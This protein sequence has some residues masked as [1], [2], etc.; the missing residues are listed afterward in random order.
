MNEMY[1]EVVIPNCLEVIYIILR[2]YERYDGE[3]V[4][5]CKMIANNITPTGIVE[6]D[7]GIC[8]GRPL[9]VLEKSE[10]IN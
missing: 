9:S 7:C 3:I 1:K 10:R 6:N 4:A 5:D 2:T 8:E